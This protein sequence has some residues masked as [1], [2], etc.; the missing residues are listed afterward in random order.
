MQSKIYTV[1]DRL[2][3]E[4]GPIFHAKNDMVAQRKFT[5]LIADESVLKA[6]D[7]QLLCLGTFDSDTCK[8]IVLDK[9]VDITE[10]VDEN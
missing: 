5:A 6:T 10:V 9:P 2:A 4:A 3:E 7:Y 8:L 1:Y